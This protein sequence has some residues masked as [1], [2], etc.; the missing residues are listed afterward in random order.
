MEKC[1]KTHETQQKYKNTQQKL[2]KPKT[3]SQNTAEV[4]LGTQERD[5]PAEE[6]TS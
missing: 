3:I 2:T 5:G 4:F 1:R 6:V